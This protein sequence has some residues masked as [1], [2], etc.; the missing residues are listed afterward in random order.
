MALTLY[1]GNTA[2]IEKH[3]IEDPATGAIEI[4]KVDRADLGNAVTTVVFPDEGAPRIVEALQTVKNLWPWHSDADGP[5]WVEAEDDDAAFA[6]KVA[7]LVAEEF[8][9]DTH[10]CAVG[11]PADWE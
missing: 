3:E 2:A 6:A 4:E 9:T 11:R 7:D 1:L 8:T 5:E 10:A